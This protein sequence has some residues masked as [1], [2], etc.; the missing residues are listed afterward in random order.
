MS[1]LHSVKQTFFNIPGF[2]TNRHIIVIESDDWGGIRMPSVGAYDRLIQ[3]GVKM[4]SYGYEKYDTIAGASDLQALFEVCNSVKDING[5]PVVITANCVVANPDFAKIK[6]D[7]FEYYHY[8]PITETIARYY[9][10]DNVFN[11]WKEGQSKQVFFPQLHGR[12]HVN[13]QMWMNSLQKDHPG[14]RRAFDE[15]VY[16]I[17]VPPELDIRKKNTTAFRHIDDN[18]KPY[19]C[20]VITEAQQLFEKL[21]GYKSLSFIAPSYSYDID[22]EKCLKE[23]GVKYMQGIH[24]HIEQGRRQFRFVGKYDRAGMLSLV[25]NADWE[26]TQNPTKDSNG[27]CLRQIADAFRWHKPATISVHRLNFIGALH[28]ENRETNLKNF[29]SLLQ[30]IQKNWPDVE[31]MTSVEL[32]NHIS[33]TCRR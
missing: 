33:E 5:R 21:F 16:S 3:A 30:A 7:N 2:H 31:F 23:N 17:V 12:E 26:P 11:L 10:N 9:P 18:E 15:G 13:V 25:R 32:G 1:I 24:T 19:Y 28:P 27:E 8:E 22:V 6:G 14:A 29:K 4:G 20:Q